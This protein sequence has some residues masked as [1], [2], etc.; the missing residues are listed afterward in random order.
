MFDR[1]VKAAVL[2]A[3][4]VPV[5]G[6]AQVME[7][8]REGSWEL[9]L[10]GGAVWIDPALRDFLTSGSPENRFTHDEDASRVMPTAV[11]RIGYNFTRNLG[12]SISGGGAMADGVTYLNPTGA[13]TYTANLNANTSPFVLIGTELTRISG[14]NG[15]ITHSTW[16]AHAGLG[17]RQMVSQNLALRLEGRVAIAGYNEVPMRR[18]TT[19]APMGTLGVSYFIGG[20]RPEATVIA[21]PPRTETVYVTRVDTVRVFRTDTVYRQPTMMMGD[22]VV[23]R[24]QFRT[25]RAELLPQSRIVLDSVAM[26]IRSTPGSSW[27]VEGHTDSVGADAANMALSRARAQS[28][29]QYLVSR[30]IAAGSLVAEGYGETRPVT[31]NATVE[32]RAQNRRVQMS[33]IPAPPAQPAP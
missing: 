23:L 14:D 4:C 3:A 19:Y 11:A 27:Q 31:T 10:S 28:V 16:G 7:P 18:N 21:D 5:V 15:R 1:I 13:L 26:A 24:V 20:R 30:G 25:N 17:I 9:S 2:L 33:R 12:V 6:S 22:Q 29:V 32:G 8:H